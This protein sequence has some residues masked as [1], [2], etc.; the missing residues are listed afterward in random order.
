[1]QDTYVPLL[2][3]EI[4]YFRRFM[5]M[6]LVFQN[7]FMKFLKQQLTIYIYC[8]FFENFLLYSMRIKQCSDNFVRTT[9]L[10]LRTEVYVSEN[11]SI[12]V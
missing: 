3:C 9:F 6:A 2:Y 11:L 1:M 7:V 5:K 12:K 4:F 10:F 8:I